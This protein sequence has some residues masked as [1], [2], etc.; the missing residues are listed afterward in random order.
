MGEVA[1]QFGVPCITTTLMDGAVGRAMATH[2]AAALPANEV[3]YACGLATGELLA[4]DLADGLKIRNGCISIDRVKG[5][6]VIIDQ[7]RLAG[8]ATG[9]TM[10][11]S[12]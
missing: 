1:A 9:K 11:F 4:Q 12:A 3:P 10:E 2:V 5:L 6:G 8:V 7:N